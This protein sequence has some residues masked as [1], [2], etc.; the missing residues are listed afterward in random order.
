MADAELGE[1]RHQLQRVAKGEVA[2]ELQAIGR[3]RRR[4]RLAGVAGHCGAGLAK[5]G[6]APMGPPHSRFIFTRQAKP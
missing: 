5:F 1:V 3:A 6:P 4:G 2:V